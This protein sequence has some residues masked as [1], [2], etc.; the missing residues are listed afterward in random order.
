[1]KKTL[2]KELVL[3]GFI[4]GLTALSAIGV[5]KYKYNVVVS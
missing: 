2:Y 5:S 3:S 4:G 1:M